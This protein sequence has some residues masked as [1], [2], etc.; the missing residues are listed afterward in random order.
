[1]TADEDKRRM[2][3]NTMVENLLKRISQT[4]EEEFRGMLDAMG[5][6]ILAVAAD[7]LTA[8]NDPEIRPLFA[9][10][11][12]V[13]ESISDVGILALGLAAFIEAILE[14]ED[15]PFMEIKEGMVKEMARGYGSSKQ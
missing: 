13:H 15:V 11:T 9:K 6:N 10:K 7:L 14:T 4:D 12:E 8:I 1:M 2:M 5:N 3:F